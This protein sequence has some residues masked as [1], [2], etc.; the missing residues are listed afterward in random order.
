VFSPIVLTGLAA[1]RR[2]TSTPTG[3]ALRWLAAGIVI[4]FGVY[5]AYSVWWGGHTFGPRYTLDLLVP[6]APAIALGLARLAKAGWGR[7][8]TGVLLLWSIAVAAA[9]AFVY[10]NEAWNTNPA[11]VDRAHHR[12]WELRDAQVFRVFRST[13][14]PQNFSLWDGP[15]VGF[16]GR[17]P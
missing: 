3:L 13:P 4:Q 17:E 8:I 10:P 16:L 7:G 12:L 5:A 6:M 9:G 15:G 2:T 14:S 1:I 11:E